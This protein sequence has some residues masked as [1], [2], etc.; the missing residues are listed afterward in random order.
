MSARHMKGFPSCL[1]TYDMMAEAVLVDLT[2]VVYI[3]IYNYNIYIYFFF[4]LLIGAITR[5]LLFSLEL[6]LR[7]NDWSEKQSFLLSRHCD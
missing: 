7:L 5:L 2:K 1:A 3:R 6:V 4:L